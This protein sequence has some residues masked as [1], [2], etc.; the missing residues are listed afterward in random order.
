VIPTLHWHGCLIEDGRRFVRMPRKEATLLVAL[1]RSKPSAHS[2]DCLIEVLWPH[3]DL[4]PEDVRNTLNSHVGHLR[5]K[6]EQFGL[7][8]TADYGNSRWLK[9]DIHIDWRRHAMGTDARRRY[10]LPCRPY[11]ELRA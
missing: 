6:I 10:A 4:E 9:G 1:A 5:M 2:W 7:R 8:I 3:P 11:E